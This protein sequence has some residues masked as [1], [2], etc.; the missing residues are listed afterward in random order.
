MC[1]ACGLWFHKQKCP[2]PRE[3]WIKK[4][5]APIIRRKRAPKK[6]KRKGVNTKGDA[7]TPMSDDSSPADTAT[8]APD[9]YDNEYD[10]GNT[11]E[12]ENTDS[13]EPQLPAMPQNMRANSAEPRGLARARPNQLAGTRQIQ[14]SPGLGHGS[15]GNP[16][17]VDLTPKSTRRQLFPSPNRPQ[18]QSDPTSNGVAAM[19]ATTNLPQFVR[20][21][22]RLN[23]TKDVFQVPGIA[24][25]VAI[26]ADGKENITPEV[27]VQ[28]QNLDGLDDLFDVDEGD[29]LPQPPSTPTP[30]RRSER[31]LTKT[32]RQFGD[33]LSTNAQRSPTFRTPKN[34]PGHPMISALLGTAMAKKDLADLTPMSRSIAE[35]FQTEFDAM[36]TPPS[37]SRQNITF[38]FPD[39][40]SLNNSSPIEM[41][42]ML[43][44]NFSELPTELPTEMNDPFSTDAVMPSSPPGFFNFIN[45][46]GM[47]EG[48]QWEGRRGVVEPEVSQYPDPE[49]MAMGPPPSGMLRRSPRKGK[50]K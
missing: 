2:R 38:D 27:E 8:D 17:N 46:D 22:P 47:Q 19:K 21:S 28:Q 16:I 40:P 18:V 10:E 13:N 39:L 3:K 14:S 20:R 6:G 35:A 9:Y 50:G 36:V 48:G 31:I 32:P 34:K 49:L 44:V 4:A 7:P 23:K 25:A 5:N 42:P 11:G 45:P 43:N 29:P 15:Q 37:R 26:T 12:D 41:D 24:G 30:T 1:K 33:E